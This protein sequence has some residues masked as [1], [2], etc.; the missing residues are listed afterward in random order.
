M[1]RVGARARHHRQDVAHEVRRHVVLVP[2]Q[3]QREEHG[4]VAL[5]QIA[6]TNHAHAVRRV[7]AAQHVRVGARDHQDIRPPPEGAR[8]VVRVRELE[9]RHVPQ[10]FDCSSGQTTLDAAA[11]AYLQNCELASTNCPSAANTA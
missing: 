11:L 4:L 1:V 9:Q 2:H 6:V 8:Q 10:L 5:A 7:V 3:R